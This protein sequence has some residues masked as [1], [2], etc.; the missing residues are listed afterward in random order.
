MENNFFYKVL[1]AVS[2]VGIVSIAGLLIPIANQKSFGLEGSNAKTK[3]QNNNYYLIIKSQSREGGNAYP[4]GVSISRSLALGIIPM[5]S[6]DACEEAGT[7]LIASQRFDSR[8]AK[9]D[10]FECIEGQ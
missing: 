3:T 8:Y 4:G 7:K 1:A 10:S 9:E 2:T 5:K 6:M